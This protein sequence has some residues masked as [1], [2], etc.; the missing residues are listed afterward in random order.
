MRWR[1]LRI[2]DHSVH[3]EDVVLSCGGDGDPSGLG[4]F[5]SDRMPRVDMLKTRPTVGDHSDR[6]VLLQIDLRCS[7]TFAGLFLSV[8]GT[9]PGTY[10]PIRC[11]TACKHAKTMSKT[12][13]DQFLNFHEVEGVDIYSPESSVCLA[14]M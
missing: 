6:Y 1:I 9:L 11:P 3:S 5:S 10:H 2:N 14:A 13:P 4:V 12:L 7:D 8:G